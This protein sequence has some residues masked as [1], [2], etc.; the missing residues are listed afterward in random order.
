M[1]K[2]NRMTDT[3][4]YKKAL[5]KISKYSTMPTSE[6]EKQRFKRLK[7]IADKALSLPS[8]SLDEQSEATVCTWKNPETCHKWKKFH[9]GCGDCDLKRQT[10]N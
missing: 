1:I 10:K 5:E 6:T 9:R 2:F 4:R 7:T 3:E 8:V